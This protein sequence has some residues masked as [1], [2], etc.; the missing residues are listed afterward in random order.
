MERD[1]ERYPR[2]P[3]GAERKL[4]ISRVCIPVLDSSPIASIIAALLF[5]WLLTMVNVIGIKES[6]RLQ[7]FT[8]ILKIV[9]LIAI[10]VFGIFYFDTNNF[11]PFNLSGE[12]SLSAIKA[13]TA[14]KLFMAC[15]MILWE[16]ITTRLNPPPQ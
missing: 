12:D 14:H 9:P 2:A 15:W 16:T 10:T 11:I 6:G 4:G 1:G 7:L 3:A 5:I 13:T 8:T